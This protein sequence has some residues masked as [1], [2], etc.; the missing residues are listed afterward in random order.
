MTAADCIELDTLYRAHNG[1][2]TSWLARRVR[3]QSRASDLMQETFCRLAGQSGLRFRD[4]PRLYLTTVARRLLIDDARRRSSEQCFLEAFA[5]HMGHHKT[6]DP[7]QIAAAVQE[8]MTLA[9]ILKGLPPKV[10]RA[11]VLS[12]VDGW[13]YAQIAADMKV[14]VSMVKKYVASALTHCYI[15]GYGCSE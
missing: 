4:H 13:E 1:W 8:L 9:D 6:A 11:F 15:C 7:E 2:L 5:L 10:R 12:R 3:C 14:S